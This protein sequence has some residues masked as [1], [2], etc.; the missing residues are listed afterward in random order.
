MRILLSNDDGIF[1][2]GLAALHAIAAEFGEVFVV[3]PATHQS[4]A[5]HAI[6]LTELI[7]EQVRIERHDPF[8]GIAVHGRPADCV[9]LAVLELMGS[10]PDLV[11]SGINAGA[12]VGVHVFY[13]GT[14][15]VAA[16]G[17][18]LGI[19]SVSFSLSTKNGAPDFRKAAAIC[20]DVLARLIDNGL[21][22]G[23]LINVNIPSRN[24][25][26]GVM[27]VPQS[28]AT[29]N[30]RY[31][32]ANISA[33]SGQ[34]T[35]RLTHCGFAKAKRDTDISAL[36]KGYVTVTPLTMTMPKSGSSPATW[37]MAVYW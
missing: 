32:L 9:R 34:R 29:L 33:D 15:A 13:S 24:K 37:V 17:A 2:P 27:V 14:V 1:E 20:R 22:A 23:E 26:K 4:A 3:A 16:E 6:T 10:P 35:Y 5:S 12:N 36:D 25:P 11:I 7:A 31:E 30:D 21:S 19:P 18:M 28:S 8:D